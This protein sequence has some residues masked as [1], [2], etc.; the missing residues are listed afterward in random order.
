M[1]VGAPLQSACCRSEVKLIWK[2]VF[3]FVGNSLCHEVLI[4]F[5]VA[6]CARA[7][8]AGA[9]LPSMIPLRVPGSRS[10]RSRTQVLQG[11]RRLYTG[12]KPV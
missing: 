9:L 12:W 5:C 6:F 10:P 4:I 1:V 11:M 7:L 3:T 2:R 8:G